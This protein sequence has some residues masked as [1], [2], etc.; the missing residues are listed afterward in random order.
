MENK[1]NKKAVK[2]K[3][4]MKMI[5]E[6]AAG[7]DVA[8]K[9]HWVSVPEG[10]DEN[11]T[12]CFGAFTEDLHR[13]ARWLKRCKITTVA[14]EST[15]V[16]WQNLF[17][18][19]QDYGFEVYLVNAHHV[20][21]VSG[22]KTDVK[23]AEWIQQ[24]HTF[25][26]LSNSF[27]PDN[28]TRS[29]RTYGRHRK[30][31]LKQTGRYVQQ[32]QKALE[33]MNIKL[34]AVIRDLTGKTGMSIIEAIVEGERSPTVLAAFRDKRIRASEDTVRKSLEGHWREEFLFLLQ[35][36]YQ[37]YCHLQEQVGAC[38]K[39]I[40]SLLAEKKPLQNG[41]AKRSATKKKHNKNAPSFDL[42]GY[43][44]AHFGVD[45]TAIDGMSVLTG[46]TILSETGCDYSKWP[47]KKQ[48]LSWLNLVPNNKISGGKV[49]SSKVM[50][51]KNTAGQAYRNAA[52][53][54]WNNKGPL[55]DYY[56]GQ[57]ARNGGKAAVIATANKLASI[58]YTMIRK[59]VEYDE[60]VII[61]M[62]WKHRQ[63]KLLKMKRNVQKLEDELR[64]AA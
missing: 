28:Y 49:L 38:D 2:A 62:N 54:L 33:Q 8:S 4:K 32:M 63:N 18:L 27:Q 25:G 29:L 56:R 5:N 19:L 6:N 36:A 48:Y 43:L 57:R 55:G 35:Q 34:P 58:V 47:T 59:Q 64:E 24:L 10:R 41:G 53:S 37:S 52:S 42:H 31:L 21:N 9:E 20:K 30:S 45:I 15:G 60:D 11:P 22:R 40:E 14:M 7:I 50:K 16:Y 12:R 46:L 1:E 3:T 13:L 17:F 61:K 39:R 23:D 44:K 26:L 51:K